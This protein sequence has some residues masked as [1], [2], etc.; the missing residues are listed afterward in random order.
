MI[1]KRGSGVG[2]VAVAFVWIKV[3]CFLFV[4]RF[5]LYPL[6]FWFYEFEPLLLPLLLIE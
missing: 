4:D 3:S 5:M 1:R 2:G 6:I